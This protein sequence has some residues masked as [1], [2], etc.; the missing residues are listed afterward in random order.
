VWGLR[1]W[2][3]VEGGTKL[4]GHVVEGRW[5]G[6][7]EN[8]P[9]GCRVY[10]P[11]KCSVSVERNVYWGPTSAEPLSRK[12]EQEES[13][14]PNAILT[15]PPPVP[16]TRAALPAPVILIPPKVAPPPDDLPAEKRVH[17]PS[18]H[19][20]DILAGQGNI[21]QHGQPTVPRGM[22][23]PTEITEAVILP[24]LLRPC[25]TLGLIRLLRSHRSSAAQLRSFSLT[26]VTVAQLYFR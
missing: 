7:D 5:V 9:N 6:I 4:G 24:E 1:V 16:V 22:Q 10:W 21:G 20:A 14:L 25:P 11:E 15:A 19:V 3:H 2:V 8:S 23:L 18:Q 26:P 12:G 13:N 17:K